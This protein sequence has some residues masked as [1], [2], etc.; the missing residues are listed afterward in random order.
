MAILYLFSDG[1]GLARIARSTTPSDVSSVDV[2][3]PRPRANTTINYTAF[4]FDDAFCAGDDGF[5]IY[6][7]HAC[8]TYENWRSADE[9]YWECQEVGHEEAERNRFNAFSGY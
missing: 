3:T 4:G 2:H 9:S 5:G 1:E 7:D 8:Y 6:D